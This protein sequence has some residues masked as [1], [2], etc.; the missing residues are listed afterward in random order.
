MKATPAAKT[1][2]SDAWGNLF[3]QMDVWW[4]L[5]FVVY[6]KPIALEIHP[7]VWKNLGIQPNNYWD[8]FINYVNDK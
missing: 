5:C 4:V 6:K 3:L 8:T 2:K 7:D 1:K